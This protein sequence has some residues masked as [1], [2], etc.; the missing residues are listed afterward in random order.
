MF[1]TVLGETSAGAEEE[2]GA[3]CIFGG[4]EFNGGMLAEYS[5]TVFSKKRFQRQ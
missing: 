4:L 1:T 2:R 3:C 5:V